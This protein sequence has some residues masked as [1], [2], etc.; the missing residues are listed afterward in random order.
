MEW[1]GHWFRVFWDKKFNDFLS[2]L[3]AFAMP[4]EPQHDKTNKLALRPVKTQISLGIRPLWSESSLSAWSTL[5]SLATHWVHIEDSDQT[6]RMP[7]WSESS[8]GAHSFCWFCHIMAH[9]SMDFCK[10]QGWWLHVYMLLHKRR[11]D[12]AEDIFNTQTKQILMHEKHLCSLYCNLSI[13]S[14]EMHLLVQSTKSH[15][16]FFKSLVMGP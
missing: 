3:Q 9:L 1:P 14:K 11:P 10:M 2:I 16:P 8:L 7:G 15:C 12:L 6:R 4:F 5:G 13:F